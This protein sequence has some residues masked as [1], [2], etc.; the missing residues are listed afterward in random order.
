[1]TIFSAHVVVALDLDEADEEAT[2]HVMREIITLVR[3]PS[4][5]EARTRAHAVGRSWEGLAVECPAG[6]A[7]VRF[8]GVRKIVPC[9]QTP[10]DDTE[11]TALVDGTVL[12]QL[13]LELDDEDSC[14]RL[15]EGDTVRVVFDS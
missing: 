12:T 15:L 14:D 11:A 1:M 9:I 2:S 8:A 10:G 13:D 4:L 3:A 7:A 5:A 6:T